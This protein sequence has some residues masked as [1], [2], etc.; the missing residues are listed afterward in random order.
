MAHM[1]INNSPGKFSPHFFVLNKNRPFR[2]QEF[3]AGRMMGGRCGAGGEW[4]DEE[5][6][7]FPP[8]V[9]VGGFPAGC[10]GISSE[11]GDGGPLSKEEKAGISTVLVIWDP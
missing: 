1:V 6:Q 3:L 7:A 11:E 4:R 8:K 2:I 9:K 10:R 5:E